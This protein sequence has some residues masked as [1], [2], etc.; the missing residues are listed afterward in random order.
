MDDAIANAAERPGEQQNAPAAGFPPEGWL[1]NRQTA[2]RLGVSLTSLTCN[3]WKWRAVLRDAARCVRVPTGGRI[4]LYP[5]E[6]VERLAGEREAAKRGPLI[7]EG[8]VD[9]DGA[10][11]FFG[12]SRFV[13]KT[14]IRQG[15][16]ACGQRIAASVGGRRTLYALKDLERMRDALF[17]DDKLYKAAGGIYHV[18]AAYLRREEAWTQFGV[19]KPTWERWERQGMIT[20][21]VRVPGGPKLYRVEDVRRL[22]EENGRFSPPYPD[23]DRPGVVRVPLGGH[24]IKRREAIIDADA[25]PLIAGGSCHWATADETSFVAFSRDGVHEVLRRV[26]MGV[27]DETVN[28]RHRN[29]DPLDCRRENL[30]VRRVRERVWSN[31]KVRA[32]NGVPTSSKFKGVHW[33]RHR[34][35][36]QA[37]ISTDGKTRYLGRYHDEAAAA[38]AYDEAA[39]ELFG[40]HAR[41]N[42]PDGVDARLEREAREAEAPEAGEGEAM[43]AAA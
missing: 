2:A 5:A 28:V 17:G 12:V 37:A 22:L 19:S 27:A 31:R 16:V 33:N 41:L 14:W 36:W 10:C 32:V 13:W 21:G 1:T 42:F 43:R 25:L 38:E 24:G 26:V 20:G 4:N 9:K 11:A 7:P 30:V 3:A 18:P 40:E 8:F 6:L 39:R 23:P 35:L 29:G 34:E 15:K